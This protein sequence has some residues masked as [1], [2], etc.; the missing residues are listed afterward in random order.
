MRR[1]SWRGA[2]RDVR[3][4]ESVVVVGSRVEI[5]RG[6]D[7]LAGRAVDVLSF[8]ER[9]SGEVW[10][11]RMRSLKSRRSSKCSLGSSTVIVR[12]W[13]LARKCETIVLYKFEP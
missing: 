5:G 9:K 12:I 6:C 11:R 7:F 3:A 10:R 8:R 1:A 13:G 4:I 2:M